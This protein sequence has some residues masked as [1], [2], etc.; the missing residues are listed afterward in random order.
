MGLNIDYEDGQTPLD[1]DEKEGL[2]IPG[3]TTR[4]E[5][6]EFEQVGVENAIASLSK[7]K[8]SPEIILT[9]DFLIDL[10]IKMFGSIWKWAG[11]FRKTNKN[12]GVDKYYIGIEIKNLLEDCQFWVNHKTFPDDEI[13]VRVSHRLVWIHPFANGNGR[14]SRL[15]ADILVSNGFSRPVFSWGSKNLI[16]KGEARS[17]YLSALRQAD[18]QDYSA[19][20]RFARS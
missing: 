16:K 9:E 10:H 18:I 8:I 1:E 5:L 7:Q 14:H 19:L 4:G 17:A 6:D 12:I 13:A 2:K 20:V 15:Y 3:I 11:E